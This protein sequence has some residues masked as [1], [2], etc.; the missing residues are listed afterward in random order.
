MIWLV[1]LNDYDLTEKRTK[2]FNLEK[3]FR[4]RKGSNVNKILPTII[5]NKIKKGRKLL[6][7]RYHIDYFDYFEISINFENIDYFERQPKQ[8]EQIIRIPQKP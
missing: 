3:K 8:P 2:V 6:S 1:S 4:K 5:S 7:S